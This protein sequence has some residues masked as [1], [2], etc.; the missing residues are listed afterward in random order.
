MTAGGHNGPGDMR[1]PHA[2][3][4]PAFAHDPSSPRSRTV[5]F[6]TL[7]A[8]LAAGLVLFVVITA[9]RVA[10]QAE[11]DETHPAGAI[12]VFGA[13][14]YAGRPSPVFRARLDHAYALFQRGI[15]PI[16]I[17]TGGAGQDPKFSEGGVGHD[18]L[19]RRGIPD[20]NLIAETQSSDTADSAQRTATIMRANGIRDCTA[21]S[22]AYHMFRIKKLVEAQGIQ[23]YAAPRPG[24]IPHTAWA[25]L[26]AAVREAISYLAWKL[27]L[28]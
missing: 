3:P 20:A 14:E 1:A 19:K 28:T 2:P 8:L 21:V 18:Y 26:V 25:R 13:A 6:W 27:D 9:V 15:A 11:I 17:T 10:R 24:S 23:V 12:V 7:L 16:V 5:R 4:Q 22:D